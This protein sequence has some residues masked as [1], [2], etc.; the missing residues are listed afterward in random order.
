MVYP[1]LFILGESKEAHKV[2][3]LFLREAQAF[4]EKLGPQREIVHSVDGL[5]I[6][7]LFLFTVW[8]IQ[9]NFLLILFLFL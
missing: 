1:Q 9:H 6:L 7:V 3:L 5:E 4:R 2:R 8:S